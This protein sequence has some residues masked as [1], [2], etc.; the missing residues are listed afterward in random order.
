MRL[1]KII[2]HES[3]PD[4]PVVESQCYSKRDAIEEP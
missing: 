2:P 1:H 3:N 4:N